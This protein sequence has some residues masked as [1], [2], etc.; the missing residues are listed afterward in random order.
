M[1]RLKLF[2]AVLAALV[3]T[4]AS[5]AGIAP[6]CEYSLRD[7][8]KNGPRFTRY[9]VPKERIAHPARPDLRGGDARLF[10]TR[11][12]EAAQEGPNFA[13]HYTIASWGCGTGC[14]NFAVID[15]KTG[16]VAFDERMR[17]L[18]NARIAFS[19]DDA[20]DRFAARLQAQYVFGVMLFRPDSALFVRL[21][22]PNE[23][24][25]R[26]GIEYFRWTGTRF[27]RLAFYPAAKLCKKPKD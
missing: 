1:T 9:L 21:G 24:E 19:E 14:L 4:S 8:P 5:A 11:L 13:G 10:R 27:A 20:D 22:Q 16:R 7:L 17:S 6:W 26:D 23:D 18:T 2:S 25:T 12:R 15:L 3:C